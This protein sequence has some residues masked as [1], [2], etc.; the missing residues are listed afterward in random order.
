VGLELAEQMVVHL[1]SA[2]VIRIGSRNVL[3]P[4][5]QAQR[6]HKQLSKA[7]SEAETAKVAGVA[8]LYASV[9]VDEEEEIV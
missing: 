1:R 4:L 8:D 5:T 7:L 2:L 3:L 9:E 6:L